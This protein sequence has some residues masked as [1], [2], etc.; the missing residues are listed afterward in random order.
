M[1]SL[2][3]FLQWPSAIAQEP[4]AITITGSVLP[5][6]GNEGDT[7]GDFTISGYADANG[8]FSG[9]A[10]LY[11][12]GPGIGP[13]NEITIDRPVTGNYAMEGNVARIYFSG[14]TGY[15]AGFRGQLRS[16]SH[17]VAFFVEGRFTGFFSVPANG[18]MTLIAVQGD[19][20]VSSP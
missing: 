3:L 13:A 6:G 11:A 20:S 14:Q 16:D 9:T 5:S 15:G 12:T 18:Y 19:G 2:L 10:H 4:V 17:T 8:V 1:S 7:T